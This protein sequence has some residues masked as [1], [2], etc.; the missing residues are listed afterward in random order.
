MGN[1]ISISFND[2]AEKYYSLISVNGVATSH[3]IEK[4]NVSGPKEAMLI[5]VADAL[6][7]EPANVLNFNMLGVPDLNKGGK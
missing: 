7:F 1:L 4:S 6:G 2:D 3:Y 5:M